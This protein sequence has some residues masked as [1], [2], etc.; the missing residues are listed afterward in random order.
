M[1]HVL[2]VFENAREIL[3][4]GEELIQ[5]L[6]GRVD[7]NGLAKCDYVW[8]FCESKRFAQRHICKGSNQQGATRDAE[9]Q[10]Q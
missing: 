10:A 4:I 5:L 6:D 8:S 2:D 1:A 7:A 9:G 3:R